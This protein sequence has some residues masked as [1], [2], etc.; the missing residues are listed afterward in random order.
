MYLVCK[1]NMSAFLYIKEISD[2]CLDYLIQNINFE[3]KLAA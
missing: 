1:P 2:F 3:V